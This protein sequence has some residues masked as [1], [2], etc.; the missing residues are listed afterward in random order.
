MSARDAARAID[1]LRRGWPIAIHAP[2]EAV[3]PLL[4]IET[5]DAARLAA[6][7]RDYAILI[8]SGRAETLKLVNQLA[9]AEPDRPV[10]IERAPWFDMA[11][12][13][14]LSD[15][16]R[17]LATP[18]KG[19]FRTIADTRPGSERDGAATGADRRAVAGLFSPMAARRK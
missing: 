2:G 13:T 9:A 14:A 16:Q 11:L 17:D 3:L 18:M 4:A 6:F 12:A 1:A 15:P 5:A 10:M 7:G 8:S 19:P